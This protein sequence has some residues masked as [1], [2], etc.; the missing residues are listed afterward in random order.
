[1]FAS[2]PKKYLCYYL[3]AVVNILNDTNIPPHILNILH[4]NSI[5]VPILSAAAVL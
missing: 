5:L 3:A 1:M 4:L 2:V